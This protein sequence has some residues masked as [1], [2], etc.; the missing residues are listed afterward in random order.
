MFFPEFVCGLFLH[1]VVRGVF[2][3]EFVCGVF[4]P[5]VVRRLFLSEVV[6]GVFFLMGSVECFFQRWLWLVSS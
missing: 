6:C 2:F 1:E 3:P 5:E 4:L